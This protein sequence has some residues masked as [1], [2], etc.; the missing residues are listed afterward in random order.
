MLM[1]PSCDTVVV[2]PSDAEYFDT[3]REVAFTDSIKPIQACATLLIDQDGL[4]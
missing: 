4:F 2:D 3:S 1:Q